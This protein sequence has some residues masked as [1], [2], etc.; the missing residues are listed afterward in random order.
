MRVT[1]RSRI[2]VLLAL[3][4]LLLPLTACEL[5]TINQIKAEPDRYVRHEV[6][7]AG[8]VVRSYSVMGRG[9]YEVDDGTGKLWVVS[10]RGVPRTGAKVAVK[11]RIK[12]AYNLGSIVKLPEPIT[13]G[14]VMI[15]SS[16]KAR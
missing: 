11:G 15:E 14:M 13:S 10:E 3:I 7:I 8:M 9:A 5:K 2:A 1:R 16:H 4:A 12:D 6:G